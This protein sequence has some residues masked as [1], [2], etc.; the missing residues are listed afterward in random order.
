MP[1]TY[2]VIPG[3]SGPL[4]RLVDEGSGLSLLVSRIGAEMVG[5]RRRGRPGW[6]GFLHR[7]GETGK[8]AGGWANHATVMGYFVH[9]LWQQRSVYRGREIRGGTHGFIRHFVFDAPKVSDD[10]S[11]ITYTVSP[12][13]IPPDAYP[14]RVGLELTY[15]LAGG[16]LTVTFRFLNGEANPAHLGFGLH[17]GFAVSSLDTFRLHLPAG[18]YV[19]YFAP[20]NFLDGRTEVIPFA[21]GEMPF[22]RQKLEGSY[23][24]GLEN[25][26]QREFVLE[27]PPSGRVVRLDFSGVPYMTLWSN[28]PTFICIEP[29]WGL[30]DSCPQLPFEQ[31]VGIQTVPAGGE[32]SA[33][34]SITPD[35]LDP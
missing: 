22:D 19:R 12:D 11:S 27:D 33:S 26:A 21:G 29:C 2:D 32:L 20:D 18:D 30:P 34:F 5:L 4:D 8:P 25:I 24:L 23:L 1:C 35:F 10:A 7:D 14:L 9:R 31:K 13:R 3:E 28:A 15:S 17:P 16:R 6:V